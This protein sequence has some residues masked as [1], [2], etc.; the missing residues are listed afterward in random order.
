MS[1]YVV[2]GSGTK[3][4][5]G[6]VLWTH[7]KE[8]GSVYSEESG[9]RGG[10]LLIHL[11]SVLKKKGCLSSSLQ[12]CQAPLYIYNNRLSRLLHIPQKSRPGIKRWSLQNEGYY[13]GERPHGQEPVEPETP[14]SLHRCKTHRTAS[15]RLHELMCK[16]REQLSYYSALR[17]KH[18]H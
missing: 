2:Q 15:L 7:R 18:A 4:A 17:G 10:G 13:T 6:S 12:S 1:L 9:Y 8:P 16:H 5:P 14:A 11:W 3:A